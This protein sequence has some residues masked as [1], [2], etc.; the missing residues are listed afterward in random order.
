[1]GLSLFSTKVVPPASLRPVAEL[2]A[3]WFV[4]NVGTIKESYRFARK[5]GIAGLD[6]YLPIVEQK[7]SFRRKAR[8]DTVE[9]RWREYPM[10]P[11]WLFLNGQRSREWAYDQ[12]LRP[13]SL[14]PSYQTVLHEQL[15]QIES[16]L[17][18]TRRIEE[19]VIVQTGDTV[20]VVKGALASSQ[21]R[22]ERI[23]TAKRRVEVVLGNMSQ[24]VDLGDVEKI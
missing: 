16:D 4:S 8:S 13:Q 19:P 2:Q 23:N 14:H 22:V 5:M 12:F 15:V 1:M 18:K 6:Y 11:G 17:A 20:K 10:F 9:W 21:G 7:S 3:V 24:E